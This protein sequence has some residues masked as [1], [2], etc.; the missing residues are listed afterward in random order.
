MATGLSR[1]EKICYGSATLTVG[2]KYTDRD[3][4]DIVAA[5]TKVHSAL[6]D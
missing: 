3:L 5:I 2:P 1:D 4:D 6:A